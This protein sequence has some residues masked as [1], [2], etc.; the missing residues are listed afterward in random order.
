[1]SNHPNPTQLI[2]SLTELG[3]AIVSQFRIISAFVIGSF[4]IVMIITA[5]ITP[6]YEGV[7]TVAF[8]MRNRNSDELSTQIAELN[9]TKTGQ[10][11]FKERAKVVTIRCEGETPTLALTKT[12]E[13]LAHVID[14]GRVEDEWAQLDDLLRKAKG[15]YELN[16]LAISGFHALNQDMGH[17]SYQIEQAGNIFQMLV[18]L[19]ISQAA[20][21]EKIARIEHTL[22]KVSQFPPRIIVE[23][24]VSTNPVRPNW[25]RN[26]G[27]GVV[28]GALLGFA[29]VFTFRISEKLNNK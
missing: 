17:K 4:T 22:K 3:W 19:Q 13:G 25:K 29:F 27:L 16:K 18:A 9:G 5:T 10:C 24:R 26:A 15:S 2:S 11:L 7:A 20:V 1:M 23:P 12:Q 8:D 14:L 6:Q 21:F 28:L